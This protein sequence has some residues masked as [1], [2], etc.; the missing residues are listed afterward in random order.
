[1]AHDIFI[2]YSSKDKQT[3]DAICHVLESNK[4][5]CWIAPRNIIAGKNYAEQI[6]YGLKNAKIV[7]LVFSKNSQESVFVNNEIDTAFSNN[8]P[9]ISFKI[10]ETLPE[11]KMGFFLKNKHWLDAYPDPE[12]VFETL[13]RDAYLLCEEEHDEDYVAPD[14]DETKNFDEDESHDL[15]E[16]LHSNTDK[17]VD[18]VEFDED[19]SESNKPIEE[20]KETPKEEVVFDYVTKSGEESEPVSNKKPE[21]KVS[22]PSKS[23]SKSSES[24][25]S[26]Y[27]YPIIIAVAIILV[28]VVGVMLL[29][30]TSVETAD[31]SDVKVEIDYVDM[32]DDRKES[33]STD[34]SYIVY[35][36]VTN[37]DN[38]SS[39]DIVHIDFYDNS[40]NVVKSNDTKLKNI[41][42]NILGAAFVNK[43]NISKVSVE[44]RDS[45]GNVIS[46][47]ESEE[48][49]E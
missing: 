47:A 24:A 3:A 21:K 41:K 11:D 10:D 12:S 27:K 4:L 30:N 20:A 28:A 32:D 37:Q 49:M 7:V 2:S 16:K 25:F 23:S 17:V 34:Y 44:L 8:K 33:Y 40:G 31:S 22:K 14:I 38:A 19:P 46:T 5:K 35:G 29:S 39:D 26:K 36:S 1:M 48:I 18:I 9:I 13:V 15:A 42:D 45:S 6:M 43:A